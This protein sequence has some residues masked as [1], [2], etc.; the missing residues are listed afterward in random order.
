MTFALLAGGCSTT[1][2]EPAT[3]PEGETHH[4]TLPVN[5]SGSLPG[6]THTEPMTR[7]DASTKVSKVQNRYT[8][9]LCKKV[10]DTWYM[11]S[12]GEGYLTDKGRF[13][14]LEPVMSDTF[15]D[16]KLEL[17][18]GEYHIVV[19]TNPSCVQQNPALTAGTPIKRDDGT[20]ET[21]WL[22]Q[23]AKG[24]EEWRPNYGLIGLNRDIFTGTV[25]F[26]VTKTGDLHS[27][28]A[29]APAQLTLTRINTW[30]R[31]LLRDDPSLPEEVRFIMGTA[32]FWSISLESL[33]DKG[34]PYGL[35]AWGNAWYPTPAEKELVFYV[36]SGMQGYTGKDGTLYSL[37]M[38]NATY[39][40]PML[41][42]D[43]NSTEG[44]KYKITDM[45]I[46]GQNT[47]L[48]TY[49]FDP[50]IE[51]IFRAN[52]YSGII[53]EATEEIRQVDPAPA[54]PA[55][56]AREGAGSTGTDLFDEFYEW[57]H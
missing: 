48:P 53:L 55:V 40:Y 22:F 42:A 51:R 28:P 15:N 30:Y 1:E 3:M 7:A 50:G 10:G 54:V 20:L 57:N 36:S 38:P 21:P 43:K 46:S 23:Y 9:F 33:D 35:D 32:N 12:K 13:A 6:D 27:D 8:Y 26:T 18:P 45:R 16:L 49:Y 34:F 5:L 4:I 56:I 29:G 17:R 44:H 41:I 37:P 11:D 39:Y 52:T 2:Q 24:T 14:D 19:L 47:H 31:T 25:D